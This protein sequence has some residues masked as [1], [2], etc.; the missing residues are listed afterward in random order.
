[1]RWQPI[2]GSVPVP[3]L[4]Q[5]DA[6]KNYPSEKELSV[7][8]CNPTKQSRVTKQSLDVLPI[9]QSAHKHEKE[10]TDNTPNNND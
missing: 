6:K 10:Q 2:V 7:L 4:E 1:M 3:T 5:C 9:L 8:N